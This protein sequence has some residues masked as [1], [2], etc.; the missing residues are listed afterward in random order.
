MALASI[1]V[2]LKLAR[3]QNGQVQLF[4]KTAGSLTVT[5]TRSSK[6]HGQ[7]RGFLF[8]FFCKALHYTEFADSQA[9]EQ[10]VRHQIT[11]MIKRR[12]GNDFQD[13]TG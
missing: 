11:K 3:G 13:Q 7:I 4:K 2:P 8:F 12:D 5:L 6:V 9:G 10:R 1:L